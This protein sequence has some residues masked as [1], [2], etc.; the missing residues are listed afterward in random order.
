MYVVGVGRRTLRSSAVTENQIKSNEARILFRE[1]IDNA[2][3][4]IFTG[5]GRWKDPPT[6]WVVSDEW[7]QRAQACLGKVD[8]VRVRKA[9]D[10]LHHVR[11]VLDDAKEG[12]FTSIN[13]WNGPTEAWFIS[14]D[15]YQEAKAC[16]ARQP[17]PRRRQAERRGK[18]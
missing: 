7:Y 16:L 6:V 5:I 12:I 1:V 3:K 2:G 15:W 9:S 18:P 13:R 17:A 4:G 10:A 14:D 8:S 11:D